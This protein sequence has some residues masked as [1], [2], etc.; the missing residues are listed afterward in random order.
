MKNV[1]LI[2]GG[3]SGLGKACAELL[4]A[5]GYIIAVLDLKIEPSQTSEDI[6]IP[7]DVSN[8]AQV[9]NAIAQIIKTFGN[10][11]VCVNCAGIASGERIIGFEAPMPL[12]HF[13][14]VININLIGTFN[15]MRCASFAMRKL[16][17]M[18][19]DGERGVIINTASIAAFEGQLGQVAYSAS[20]GGVASMTL[21]AAR[22]FADFGIRVVTIA[23]GLFQTPMM[24]NIPEAAQ[25]K[26]QQ[27]TLFPKRL[28]HAQEYANCVLH[29]IQ[30]SMYNGCTIRLDGGV[31]LNRGK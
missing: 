29:I 6:H 17:P 18:N 9:E 24:A 11:R 5:Q 1:A 26:L 12:E 28:G 30:N 16:D 10:I 15:V 25:E 2:T 4:R 23:P 21:P 31:R 7:C 19:Q 22:E 13:Q 20:K 3:G 8:A 27:A 14:N